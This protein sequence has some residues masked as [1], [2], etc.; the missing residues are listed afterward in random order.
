[1][2]RLH[3]VTQRDGKAGG[4]PNDAKPELSRPVLCNLVGSTGE[5]MRTSEVPTSVEAARSRGDEPGEPRGLL[6]G[7]R[8]GP[9]GGEPLGLRS[10]LA[11][12][13]ERSTDGEPL[14]LLSAKLPALLDA[15]RVF[16][17]RTG[18]DWRDRVVALAPA[19]GPPAGL[20]LPFCTFV[21]TRE[22]NVKV[23]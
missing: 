9:A 12:T 5:D 21:A 18:V 10:E 16:G 3:E 2:V 8:L 17:I 6:L 1:M 19:T 15:V 4:C 13:R 22:A 14:G 7:D 23:E 20:S 11:A